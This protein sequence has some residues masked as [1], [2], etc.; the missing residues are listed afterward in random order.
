METDKLGKI[1]KEGIYAKPPKFKHP[2]KVDI[3]HLNHLERADLHENGIR[4][5]YTKSAEP[6]APRRDIF[7]FDDIEMIAF[8]PDYE[9]AKR[10]LNYE[11]KS[12]EKHFRR[13]GYRHDVIRWSEVDMESEE[14]LDK[15]VEGLKG[16]MYIFAHD[17][18]VMALPHVN[19][20]D[21]DWLRMTLREY[22]K[23]K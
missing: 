16:H 11:L 7:H 10:V 5:H 4:F 20:M 18:D 9:I 6:L 22:V 15:H 14:S 13:L 17:G 12:I 19:L 3:Y 2:A 8:E 21:Q 1:L 23:V